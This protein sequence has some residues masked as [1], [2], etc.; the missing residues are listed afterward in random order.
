MSPNAEQLFALLP[1]VYRNR[2]G[3]LGGTLQAL[4]AVL[5]GQR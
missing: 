1:V 5:A 3:D 2:D 4:Y